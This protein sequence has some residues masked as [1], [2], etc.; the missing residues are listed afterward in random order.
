M[1]D[2]AGSH[3][4][5]RRQEPAHFDL[6]SRR[7]ELLGLDWNPFP[8]APDP[9]SYCSSPETEA[10]LVEILH[11]VDGRKGFAVLT[12]E[13]GL[14]KTTL[15]RRL[16]QELEQRGV[17]TSLIFNTFLEGDDLLREINRDFGIEVSESGF[18]A[19]L[20]ALS[21]FLLE[22]RRARRNC[23]I[24]I[25][26]A[27]H[28]SVT[29]L[30]M[31]RQISNLEADADKL[32]QIILVGQP[33]LND[34]LARTELR[35]LASR[36]VL[37]RTVAP[38]EPE[39]TEHYIAFRLDDASRDGRLRVSMEAFPLIHAYTAGVPRRIN[40][41]MDRCL[42]AAIAQGS[43]V[44]T[45]EVVSDAI[46]DLGD[47]PAAPAAPSRAR[48]LRRT[49]GR[50]PP[51]GVAVAAA[52]AVVVG[53][54]TISGLSAGVTPAAVK[55]AASTHWPAVRPVVIAAFD[56]SATASPGESPSRAGGGASADGVALSDGAARL[57]KGLLREDQLRYARLEEQTTGDWIGDIIERCGFATQRDVAITVAEHEDLEF[58]DV[59]LL[60][61]QEDA[62]R[63]F[64]PN[65]CKTNHLLPVA[66]GGDR[67]RVVT[68]S[69][70][71]DRVASVV[72][73][74]SGLHPEVVVGEKAKLARAIQH[75]YYFLD[76]PIEETLEREIAMLSS[77]VEAV[78]SLD[79]LLDQLFQ[80]AV[81]ERATDIHI[82]STERSINLSFRVDG[83]LTPKF[84]LVPRLKRLISTVKLKARMDIA[85]QRLPQ[86]GS[87]QVTVVDT[88]YDI[89]ASTTVSPDGE[90]IVLRLLARYTGVS[91]F[92]EL[93][94]LAP[95]IPRL[96][97]MF[98]HPHGIILLTGPTGS[99]KTTTLYAGVRA[100][101]VLRRNILTVENPIEYKVPLIR[102]T[103]VN[104]KAGY[105]FAS[106]IRHFLRHDPDI[107]LVGEIRD[108]ETAQTA[109][110]AA[111]TGHLVL[112]TLHT[113]TVFGTVPRLGSLGI[114]PFM[115]ADSL[116]GV[117]GQRL[118]RRL[119]GGCSESYVPEDHERRML[120]GLHVERL[121]RGRGCADCAGTGYFGRIPVYEILR[122]SGEVTECIARGE[123]LDTL[124]KAAIADGFQDIHANAMQRVASG[125]TSLEEV[126]RVLGVR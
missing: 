13:V 39:V 120:R 66:I 37:R 83:L 117:V 63:A 123:D 81:K 54:V 55:Q 15:S 112:S 46:A 77:D 118:V 115:L 100:Q 50:R 43:Y 14:G 17:Q 19:Q 70:D 31:I 58:V 18:R 40:L 47:R 98:N 103:E 75:Y 101:D 8:M 90:N 92:P 74:H 73:R 122:V 82:V 68:S 116:V 35:Q 89:R 52:I 21:A 27:Q 60:V 71:I 109:I 106:A 22:Q 72:A 3:R 119:C 29:S 24:V 111:E 97:E 104:E 65:V 16:L 36:V 56:R 85:E 94:F 84:S 78:R 107:I 44:I 12:G 102:Q 61:P 64:K 59:S 86:D 125:I 4:G 34:T 10:L 105:S 42:Y 57:A 11:V 67:V 33:E 113:N 88:S 96:F 48:V 110:T 32:V 124:R 51:F 114:T 80:L 62:L 20:S 91:G 7:L 95:D 76:N 9:A 30:E 6:E 41:L 87:F 79:G 23:A 28:L 121:Y 93:G 1:M 45:P 108:R 2:P 69:A 26:D 38:F 126:V 99:G 53:L 49:W 5:S 25:D